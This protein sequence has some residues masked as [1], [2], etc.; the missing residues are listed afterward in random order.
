MLFSSLEQRMFGQSDVQ[1]L[2]RYHLID[3]LGRGAMGIVYRAYDP[4]LD[5]RVA[6]KV[7]TLDG[8]E[9]RARMVREAK[10]LAKLNH[11]NVVTVHEVGEDGDDLFVV[12]EYVDGGTLSD[13]MAAHPK[14]EAGRSEALLEFAMQAL[15]GL[16]A[17]HELGLVHRDIKPANLLIGKDG[18]LRIGDFGLA[19]AGTSD[20]ERTVPDAAGI[21]A[22]DS[23]DSLTRAG[24]IVG[25]P[26]F[27][28]P[29]QFRGSADARSD[30]FGLAVSFY[31]AFFDQR[32][33][34]SD[35]ISSLL[36]AMG[37][38]QV[39]VPL[40]VVPNYVRDVLLRAMRAEA[41]DR[42]EDARAM[43]RALRAGGRR[44]TRLFGLAALGLGAASI[45][46]VAWGAAP[47]ACQDERT[48]ID[49]V[50][51]SQM[52]RI[53]ALL[54]ES[55]RPHAD[56]LGERFAHEL[57]GLADQWVER[58]L[59]A[60]RDA[61]VREPEKA[62]LAEQ[63]LTCLDDGLQSVEHALESI[64]TMTPEQAD[65]LPSLAEVLRGFIDCEDPDRQV[66]DARGRELLA[67]FRAAHVAEVRFDFQKSREL[68]ETILAST[69][70]GE[71]AD[72]RAEVY[73]R[74]LSNVSG[75]GDEEA[76]RE[77]TKQA[78]DEAERSGDP[79]LLAYAWVGAAMTLPV[80]ESPEAMEL[81]LSLSRAA[82]DRGDRSDFTL[83]RLGY[84]EATVYLNWGQFD[85]ALEVVAET[86]IPAER[87]QSGELAILYMIEASLLQ[88]N[89]DLDEAE[90]L[91]EAALEI[92]IERMG[93]H[94]PDVATMYL[95]LGDIQSWQ[96]DDAQSVETLNLAVEALGERPGFYPQNLFNA[97]SGR[98]DA[99][100]NMGQ[101]EEAL[102]D[103]T[104][105]REVAQ[106]ID[107]DGTV[108]VAVT[109][110]ATARALTMMERHAESLALLDGALSSI[111][112][113]TVW[114]R[115]VRAD[116]SV[117]RADV[118]ASLGRFDDARAQLEDAEPLVTEAFGE[119][120]VP[121][122]QAAV[123][124]ADVWNA[125]GEHA[126]ADEEIERF[127]TKAENEPMFRGM[128]ERA[129]AEVLQAQGQTA[130]AR[131][132][133]Q[134]ALDSM[135]ESGAGEHEFA[136]ILELLDSL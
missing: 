95:R 99:Y 61:R 113:K 71:A 119:E 102:K 134:R 93:P 124:V 128:L 18:R 16:A 13:W 83:T 112:G 29:E 117:L 79:D 60:C 96:G 17:A 135:K 133:A 47:E 63:R 1:R 94:H 126:R 49:A 125:I 45:G 51:S 5:R 56:E 42:F 9:A 33:F 118:L 57:D 89:G 114:G 20:L 77:Y 129:K 41:S 121:R 14:G 28:A 75:L 90:R 87:I 22:A 92:G 98:G 91:A 7:V 32:P 2:G 50:L 108:M 107:E 10:A 12:M 122:L 25:T 116:A 103:Y 31:V 123:Q 81:F 38:N 15:E 55:G 6:I 43:S 110:I 53:D 111:P 69:Q 100:R 70:K 130:Q 40:G 36:E 48:R 4:D 39:N 73:L 120:G 27:M 84:A 66:D 35:S 62:T 64:Q 19:R 104:R 115:D 88:R 52:P 76:F 136:P 97:L 105:A 67:T 72:L 127:L 30:Q 46:A 59:H 68:F 132:W 106:T 80:G 24:Q 131:V 26:A 101:F 23:G 34:E 11:P 37:R 54:A 3:T 109:D 74:L 44:R 8:E 21:V 82:R 86:R 85:R 78:V 65:A 58:R